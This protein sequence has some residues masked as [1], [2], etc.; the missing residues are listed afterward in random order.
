M[1]VVA[2][3]LNMADAV[4]IFMTTSFPHVHNTVNWQGSCTF[5]TVESE[6][7]AFAASV[8]VVDSQGTSKVNM[9][10]CVREVLGEHTVL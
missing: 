1:D 3:P 2:V 4:E 7:P 8:T 6:V 9:E 5:G 10:G